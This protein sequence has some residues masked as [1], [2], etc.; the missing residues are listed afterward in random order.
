MRWQVQF[1]GNMTAL[2]LPDDAG[3]L[4]TRGV[5]YALFNAS[6][7]SMVPY[8]VLHVNAT[9]DNNGTTVKCIQIYSA[10][11]ALMVALVATLIVYGE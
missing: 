9:V 5:S 1:V 3:F 8:S 11:K 2:R 10:G 4:A 6:Q 7:S